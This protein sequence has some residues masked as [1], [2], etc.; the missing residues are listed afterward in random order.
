[1]AETVVIIGAG[2]K[3]G[4]RA[5][6]KIG[7][8]PRY[9]VRMC[10][11]SPSHAQALVE[12]GFKVTPVESALPEAD[13]VILAV[14]DAVIGSLAHQFVPQMKQG[15]TLIML[16]AAAAYVGE[17]PESGDV[18]MMITHPCHPPFFTEQA[19]PEARRDCFGGTAFQ[20]ILVSLAHGPEARFLAGVELCKAVFSPVRSA[21]RVTPEQFALLEPAM[22]ELVVATAATLMK[23][24]LDMAIAKGVPR[25]AAQAFMAGHARIATAIVFGAEPSP[26]S[27]AAQ[28]AIKWGMQEIIREDWR[29]VFEP[30]VLRE[31]IRVMLHGDDK[32]A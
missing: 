31:A 27:D 15:A 28:V 6:E 16:D 18:T 21:Y 2:G 12:D 11:S 20:D 13:Y 5:A 4:R 1:M 25:E 23:D 9:Q 8:D 19:T 17:L 10:E 3:M 24:S 26:F 32:A 22:A 30:E 7:R 14:P 29:R